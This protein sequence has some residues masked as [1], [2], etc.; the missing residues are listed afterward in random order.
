MSSHEGSLTFARDLVDVRVISSVEALP[1][2]QTV[3]RPGRSIAAS[4]FPGDDAVAT[5]HYGAFSEGQLLGIASLY[6]AELPE[7]PGAT[8]WQLRGMATAPEARGMGFGRALV[9][10][11][12]AFA[13]ESGARLLWCN[14]RTTAVGF[15]LK[16]GFQTLGGEFEIPDVGPHFRMTLR[17]GE[18]IQRPVSPGLGL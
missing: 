5:C 10:A 7:Q 3:L 15:Y 17:F 12:I 9:L 1:L 6:F 8:A 13:R 11:C 4:Q 2:R 14:A 16:L 18:T